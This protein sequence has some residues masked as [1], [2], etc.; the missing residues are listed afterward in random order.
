MPITAV[1]LAGKGGNNG[2][3]EIDNR[4]LKVLSFLKRIITSPILSIKR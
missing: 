2:R 4:Q 3:V 1:L